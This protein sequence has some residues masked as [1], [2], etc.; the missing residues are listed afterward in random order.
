MKIMIILYI[1]AVLILSLLIKIVPAIV[2]NSTAECLLVI[3]VLTLTFWAWMTCQCPSCKSGSKG[4]SELCQKIKEYF[5]SDKESASKTKQKFTELQV[6]PFLKLIVTSWKII[7]FRKS[8]T[9]WGTCWQCVR[10]GARCWDKRG[11]TQQIQSWNTSSTL[12]ISSC[13]SSSS[14]SCRISCK[15]LNR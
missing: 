2:G 13:S 14:F 12:T 6:G 3:F 7:I 4:E 1:P 10:T 8:W 11:Q 9:S 5:L 15:R